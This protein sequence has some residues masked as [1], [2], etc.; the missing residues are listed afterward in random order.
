MR[1]MSSK[2]DEAL[3]VSAVFDVQFPMIWGGTRR[4]VIIPKRTNNITEGL[5]SRCCRFSIGVFVRGDDDVVP[6]SGEHDVRESGEGFDIE[7]N[8][9][10]ACRHGPRHPKPMSV[11]I[12][13][14]NTSR[15][16]TTVEYVGSFGRT[17]R[18]GMRCPSVRRDS[19]K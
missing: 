8:I 10:N 5:S 3:E 16:C 2:E 15:A 6:R 11:I 18:R 19:K 4:V 1:S 17:G 12:A 14:I 13:G 9:E 7:K